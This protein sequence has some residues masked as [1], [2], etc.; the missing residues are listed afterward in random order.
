M[1]DNMEKLEHV[2]LVIQMEA[3]S[4]ALIIASKR[5][6]NVPQLL[7]SKENLKTAIRLIEAI[8]DNHYA[9]KKTIKS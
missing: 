5:G 2:Q 3:G 6:L 9:T 1:T 4:L 7:R 8:L